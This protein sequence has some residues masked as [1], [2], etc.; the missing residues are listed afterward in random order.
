MI[1]LHMI[2]LPEC[3]GR[4]NLVGRSLVSKPRWT[5]WR[6]CLASPCQCLCFLPCPLG[7]EGGIASPLPIH[8]QFGGGVAHASNSFV[9][10]FAFDLFIVLSAPW[11]V[12]LL[13]L[14]QPAS[15]MTTSTKLQ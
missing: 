7:W 6:A 1:S 10:L 11:A 8:P 9:S 5:G 3:A 12:G 2:S 4:V 15:S 13:D 14:Q